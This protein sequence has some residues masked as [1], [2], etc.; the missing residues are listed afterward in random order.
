MRSSRAFKMSLV[1]TG[2]AVPAFAAEQDRN[3]P[4]LP[5]L[6]RLAACPRQSCARAASE[7]TTQTQA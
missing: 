5:K 3:Q 7:H 2:M 6:L 4:Q 1:L